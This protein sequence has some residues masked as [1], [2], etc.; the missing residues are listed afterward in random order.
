ML[1]VQQA[2]L[3]L[4]LLC[5]FLHHYWLCAVCSYGHHNTAYAV[6]LQQGQPQCINSS[7]AFHYSFFYLLNKLP[8][9]LYCRT[10]LNISLQL[11][12]R[13]K[14]H[15]LIIDRTLWYDWMQIDRNSSRKRPCFQYSYFIQLKMNFKVNCT[16][17]LNL[18]IRGY[19]K[20]FKLSHKLTEWEA[21]I[22]TS[23]LAC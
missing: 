13:T 19:G 12:T 10:Y 7:W 5:V 23:F 17:L 1:F 15:E 14:K 22:I 6:G 16:V 21:R 8:E 3:L 2:V 4:R 9:I 11:C 20:K 18:S